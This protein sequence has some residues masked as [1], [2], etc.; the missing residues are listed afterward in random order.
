MD[1]ST[2]KNTDSHNKLLYDRSYNMKTGALRSGLD[3]SKTV[4]Q[5]GEEI[6]NVVI[7][8]LITIIAQ[9]ING[10]LRLD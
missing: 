1:I 9:G 3:K 4:G 10:F 2:V 6:T 5:I 8:K 7:F